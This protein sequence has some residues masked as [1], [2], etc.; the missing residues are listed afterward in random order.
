MRR[1]TEY[2]LEHQPALMADK[3]AADRH[4]TR[5]EAAAD[6]GL[7][8]STVSRA[9][10][11]KYVMLPSRRVLPFAVFF[12]GSRAVCARLD[13]ILAAEERPLTDSELCQ[14]L[15]QAGYSVA[16]RTVAK[17]RRRLRVLPSTYR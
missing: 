15:E 1:I 12:D 4:L 2:L 17:Y 9:T 13:A 5:A 10:A 11:G 7:N 8:P 6:L 3:P 16:R 14:R